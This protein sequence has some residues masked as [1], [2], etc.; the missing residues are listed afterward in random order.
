MDDA[1]LRLIIFLTVL[2]LMAWLEW[3]APRRVLRFGY[4]RWPANLGIVVLDALMVRIV[5]PA[6]AVGA[7]LW[8]QELNFGLFHW[9]AGFD[10][11]NLPGALIVFIAVVLLDLAIY[12]QHVLF[13][14]LPILWRLHLVHHADRDIDVTTGLRFHPIEILLSMIIKITLVMLLGAP[15]L[16]VIIFEVVLN[17]MA[18]FNHANVALP[19]KLDGWLRWLL[20]TPDVHRIHHS[21]HRHETNSNYG[22]NLSVWDRLFGTYR[23][24]PQ[25]GHDD[26]VIGLQHL[27][28]EPT[29]KLAF[30]LRLPFGSHIGQYPILKRDGLDR[31]G[32]KQ[33]NPKG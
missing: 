1:T 3:I 7:A 11:L 25:D 20:I 13:H 8:A 12:A 4:K 18:M 15:V 6:G 30:M 28:D 26:M 16:A 22:F 9:L 10:G 5:L 27:Q 19:L 29:H 33:N 2:L 21:I 23:A 31:N 14:A 17:A 32:L 24:Q